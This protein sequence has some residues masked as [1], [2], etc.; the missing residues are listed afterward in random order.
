M[1]VLICQSPKFVPVSVFDNIILRY[2]P[3]SLSERLNELCI[4][5]DPKGLISCKSMCT[6]LQWSGGGELAADVTSLAA[7][8]VV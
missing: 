6:L 2:L 7:L 3:L 8:A 5:L 1:I 4:V